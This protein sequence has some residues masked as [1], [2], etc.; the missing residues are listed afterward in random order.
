MNKIIETTSTFA[1]QEIERIQAKGTVSY[2]VEKI[3]DLNPLKQ[4]VGNQKEIRDLNK[5][6]KA[7]RAIRARLISVAKQEKSSDDRIAS[8]T[9]RLREIKDRLQFLK[10]NDKSDTILKWS[11]PC[12]LIAPGTGDIVRTAAYG[13]KVFNAAKCLQTKQF[14]K[15]KSLIGE[16]ALASILLV[17]TN[18]LYSNL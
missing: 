12:N 18:V 8:I 1:K 15:A 11:T 5:R 4:S 7:L 2:V 9:K 3:I 13:L 17:A 16:L 14:D 10:L 6:V